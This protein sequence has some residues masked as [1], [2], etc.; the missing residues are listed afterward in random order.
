MSS[1]VTLEWE[2]LTVVLILARY[3][4]VQTG[5]VGLRNRWQ[6]DPYIVPTGYKLVLGNI[7]EPSSTKSTIKYF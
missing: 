1:I 5:S 3:G 4:T 6:T 7:Y 2:L